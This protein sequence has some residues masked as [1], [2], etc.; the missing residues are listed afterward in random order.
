MVDALTHLGLVSYIC[1][2]DISHSLSDA[3]CISQIPLFSLYR[4]Y[5]PR[6]LHLKPILTLQIRF[7][8]IHLVKISVEMPLKLIFSS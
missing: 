6:S 1:V 2:I 4:I 7:Q 3:F 5:C 8:R